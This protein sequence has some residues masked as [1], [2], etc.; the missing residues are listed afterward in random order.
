MER[1]VKIRYRIWIEI[2]GEPVLGKGG[3][4]L[5]RAIKEE[6]SLSAASRRLG[7]SYVFAWEY[8]QRINEILGIPVVETK[9]GGRGGGTAKLTKTGER[10]LALYEKAEKIVRETLSSLSANDLSVLLHNDL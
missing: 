9:R 10:L 5:L 1:S 3:A 2:D 6:G 8:L 7:V 4:N